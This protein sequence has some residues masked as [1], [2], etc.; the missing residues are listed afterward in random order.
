[1]NPFTDTNECLQNNGECTQNCTDTIGS[2]VCSCNDGFTLSINRLSC[3]GKFVGLYVIL[4]NMLSKTEMVINAI[5]VNECSESNGGCG[6]ICMNTNGSF[7][8]SCNLGYKLN[9]D[10][11]SC[12]G[13]Y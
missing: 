8:C 6:Q 13:K 5:D 10:R 9:S 1:M 4:H 7:D 11:F 2:F 3:F 12:D